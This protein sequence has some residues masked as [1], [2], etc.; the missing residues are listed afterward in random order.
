MHV[1]SKAAKVFGDLCVYDHCITEV[2]DAERSR[3]KSSDS[4]FGDLCVKLV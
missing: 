4:V 2:F 1:E 3:K